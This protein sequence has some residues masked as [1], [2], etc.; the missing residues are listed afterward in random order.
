M[1]NIPE[2]DWT[3]LI[4][5][6][7]NN[8]LEPEMWQAIENAKTAGSHPAVNVVIEIGR[9]DY[10]LVKLVRQ[11]SH[12]KTQENWRG[13]RR[14]LAIPNKLYWLAQLKEMNMAHPER[15]YEFIKWGIEAYPAK[16]YMLILGGHGYQFVGA[17][18]D[19]TQKVP[20]IMGIPEM[21]EA[22]NAAGNAT[23]RKIDLLML[24]IC[25]F[26]FI[27][28]IYE[29]GKDEHHAVQN[30][31]TYVYN[32]PIEGLPYDKITK[33]LQK[34][35]HINDINVVIRD[36]IDNLSYDLVAFYINHQ[37]LKEIKE[38]FNEIALEITASGTIF[39][40]TIKLPDSISINLFSLVIHF[41]KVVKNNKSLIAV[42]KKP[43]SDLKLISRYY[44]LGFAQHNY[45][46]YLLSNKT[47]AVDTVMEPK[48]NLRPLKLCQEEVY[49]FI[50][51]MNPELSKERKKK[52][53][54]ELFI[55]RKWK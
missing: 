40:G 15:L 28:V 8:E 4:Y 25:Y 5:A 9:A 50:S 6:N 31:L 53:L 55:Q 12:P 3:I 10:K 17:M 14:Y 34:N 30:A 1:I 49:A 51:I 43:T 46:T 27:E 54:K 39:D 36:L 32:G 2:K 37:L 16:R 42:A 35:S 24:D 20:Y 13:V 23:G 7:G 21:V 29:L 52:I 18:T 48:K 26:N 41:K 11:T 38:Q 33:V 47:I 45:W 44:R 19:Y 22:I